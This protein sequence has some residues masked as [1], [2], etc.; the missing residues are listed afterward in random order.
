MHDDQY[1]IVAARRQ[2]YDALLWQVP[3]LGVAAQSFIMSPVIDHSIHSGLK[4]A[5]LTLSFA[6]GFAVI[7]LFRKLRYH[8]VADAKLLQAFETLRFSEGYEVVHGRRGQGWSAYTV[9]HAILLMFLL[10]EFAGAMY[11]S[12]R[13]FCSCQ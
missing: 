9:W 2:G 1:P 13:S 11:F 4:A 3:A 8:E 10:L 5:L 12:F 7:W 6:L